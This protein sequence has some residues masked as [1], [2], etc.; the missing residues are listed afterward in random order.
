MLGT[1]TWLPKMLVVSMKW[2]T[3]E[4]PKVDRFRVGELAF[5]A[6]YY[7]EARRKFDRA[8][9]I[10]FESGITLRSYPE[11][12]TFFQRLVDRISALEARA[13]AYPL[14]VLV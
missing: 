8:V 6:G 13:M 4:R 11:L 9:D 3:R 2:I 12:Q 10:I 1:L 14:A 7:A 5:Q